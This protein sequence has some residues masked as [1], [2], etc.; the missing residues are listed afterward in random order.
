MLLRNMNQVFP[1]LAKYDV[2]IIKESAAGEEELTLEQLKNR[3]YTYQSYQV[4][5]IKVT[6]NRITGKIK[7]EIYI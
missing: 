6:P 5:S 7:M 2:K 4:H 3:W 1:D